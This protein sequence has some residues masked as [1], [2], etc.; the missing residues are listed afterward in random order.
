MT[1]VV[2]LLALQNS[3]FFSISSAKHKIFIQGRLIFVKGNNLIQWCFF[4]L[5]I[6]EGKT[7]QSALF[8]ARKLSLSLINFVFFLYYDYLC[9]LHLWWYKYK[10]EEQKELKIDKED[11]E[12]INDESED[13]VLKFICDLLEIDI[14]RDKN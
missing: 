11:K 5:C 12:V 7:K 14:V 1:I 2:L 4:K 10:E 13:E 9:A 3:R 8:K 6:I